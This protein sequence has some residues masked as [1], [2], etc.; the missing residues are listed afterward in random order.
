[1]AL[2]PSK[3]QQQR[4][5]PPASSLHSPRPHT[6]E[7]SSHCGRLQ[8][9]FILSCAANAHEPLCRVRVC[10]GPHHEVVLPYPRGCTARRQ[11]DP[12]VP[13]TTQ[14]GSPGW[15]G[16]HGG[17]RRLPEGCCYLRC[18]LFM[19]SV[20]S[21]VSAL[22]AEG[23]SSLLPA[24]PIWGTQTHLLCVRTVSPTLSPTRCR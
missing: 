8:P 17:N 3:E 24:A 18:P 1:M 21:P 14:G 6:A 10:W 12:A 5:T 13:H 4:A 20:T 2:G 11:R 22:K 7:G 23:T 16:A 9:G 19:L 15:G